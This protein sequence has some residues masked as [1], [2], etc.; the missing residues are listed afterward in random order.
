MQWLA[1]VY[2][3]IDETAHTSRIGNIPACSSVGSVASTKGLNILLLSGNFTNYINIHICLPY[4]ISVST[5]TIK[6]LHDQSLVK[7]VLPLHEEIMKRDYFSKPRYLQL[8][9]CIVNH[10]GAFRSWIPGCSYDSSIHLPCP[11]LKL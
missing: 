10:L 2:H 1:L 6:I 4:L 3:G 8:C 9:N 5:K 7:F 11:C